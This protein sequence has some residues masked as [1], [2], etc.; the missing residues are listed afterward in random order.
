LKN[1][2]SGNDW[3]ETAG[4]CTFTG[5][6]YHVIDATSKYINACYESS[7]TFSNFAFEVQM[8]IIKG[9]IGGMTF[10]D[11]KNGDQYVLDIGQDG[12]Y[13]LYTCKDAKTC[14]S[15][16]MD[17]YTQ[18]IN[19]GLNVTNLIAVVAR[20]SN[21]TLYV[22]HQLV[23]SVTDTTYKAGVV[24]LIANDAGD[25]TEVVYRNARAWKF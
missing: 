10:R 15:Y 9:D 16:L 18:S 12:F 4:S 1:N 8:T 22:N 20:G 23:D 21:I 5:G 13:E 2:S 6:A 17:D 14:G 3:V 7:D 19:R 25:A 24:G 11:D